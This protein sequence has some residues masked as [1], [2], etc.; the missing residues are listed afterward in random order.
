M[1][2][3]TRQSVSLFRIMATSSQAMEG[4]ATRGSA[5]TRPQLY[6]GTIFVLLANAISAK[7]MQTV[8]E[9]GAGLALAGGGG[10]SWAVW[11][12]MA[13]CLRLALTETPSAIR[14]R[15][16]WLC[17]AGLAAAIFPISQVSALA[18]TALALAVF[19][20]RGQGMRLKASAMV[21]AAISVPLLWSRLLMLA[22][23]QPIASFD[24]RMV[25]LV[26][27]QP[28]HG[29]EVYFA[30]GAY[31][32][33]ILAG[34]TSVQNA[35]VALVLYVAV[36]RSFRPIPRPGELVAVAG[37]FLSV[38]AVNIVR[39]SL[40]AQ[41]IDMFHLVHGDVGAA[42]VNLIVTLT[43]LAWAIASVR[44]EILD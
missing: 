14:P 34:C 3:F 16:L 29:H 22:F 35:S 27:G 11:L 23:V 21:L 6:A 26:I 43:G 7:L 4:A 10:L 32:M 25:S 28:A 1:L 2:S 18:C 31:R 44:R 37:V 9:Q 42:V 13:A 12:A 36:V 19:L 15:D 8:A 5:V 39:L 38:I 24:A 40:M 33:S 17:G 41:N 20:D 30:N